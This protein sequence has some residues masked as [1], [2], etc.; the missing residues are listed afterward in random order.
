MS[1]RQT[2]FLVLL[3]IA[4]LCFELAFNARLLDVV[5]GTA[6]PDQIHH[7]EHWGR[8]LS[9]IALALFVL[10]VLLARR[11]K[12][13]NG[14]P[15]GLAIV[16]WCLAS[17]VA[18]FLFLQTLVDTLVTYSSPGFRRISLNMVLVQGALVRGGVELDGLDDDPGLFAQPAGKAFL[19]L[20]PAMAV[21]V[22]R[23]DEKI[24]DAKLELIGRQVQRALG[25]AAGYYKSYTEAV[26]K[27]QDQWQ[28]Y[29]RVP[30]RQDV[31]GEVAR[32]QDQAWSEYL[33][34]LG[35]RGWTPSTVP[36]M[37]RSAVLRKVR[38]KI[39]V[40]AQSNSYV[41]M[42]EIKESTVLPLDR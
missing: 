5:G 31:E 4:Y 7:I 26:K 14:S 16:F 32:R 39:P 28:R 42:E 24:R 9:G 25:G 29:Q 6:S 10:Q 11:N 41:V 2:L 34:D 27:T 35:R 33:E 17:G 40:P 36:G 13:R 20:F 37:A 8:S 12:S 3:T 38:A 15:R 21:S 19:A 30:G 22:E 23:L 18:M 1:I